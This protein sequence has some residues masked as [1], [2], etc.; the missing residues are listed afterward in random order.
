MLRLV[1]AIVVVGG[2]AL[3]VAAVTGFVNPPKVDVAL[4]SKGQTAVDSGLK[5][6]KTALSDGLNAAAAKIRE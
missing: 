5:Q 2:L 3:G 1:G 4:T 6:G